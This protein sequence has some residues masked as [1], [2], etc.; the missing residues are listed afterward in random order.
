MPLPDY[1]NV[2]ADTGPALPVYAAPHVVSLYSVTL[3]L[4]Q[5]GEVFEAQTVEFMKPVAD[6]GK[7]ICT[8]I[9][10]I[11]RIYWCEDRNV[12]EFLMLRQ[13]WLR[14]SDIKAGVF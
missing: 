10:K 14:I 12:L 1:T 2:Q 4:G 9:V 5:S 11:D 8:C 6:V 3:F 13:E 7:Y